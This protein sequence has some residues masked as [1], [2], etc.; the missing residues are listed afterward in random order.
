MSI[1]IESSVRTILVTG[2]CGF[3]GSNVVMLLMN[4]YSHIHVVNLDKMDYNSRTIDGLEAERYTFVHGN[5]C[6]ES[7]VLSLLRDHRVDVVMHFA[8]QSHVDRSFDTPRLFVEDNI[9]GTLSLMRA[10]HTYGLLRCLL[11]F[12]TDEIYGDDP[13]CQPFTEESALNPTNP[14][15]A[16]K[17]AAEMMVRSYI[18][19]FSIPVV[20]AR[21]NNIYGPRQYKDKVIP[22]FADRLKKGLVCPVH[23]NGS[24][25]RSFIHVRDVY[26]AIKCVLQKGAPGEVYNIGSD[27]ELSILELVQHIQDALGIAG[28]PR[29]EHIEDRPYNDQRYLIDDSKLRSLGWSPRCSLA[30]CLRDVLM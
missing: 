1:D 10:I 22:L 20:I 24:Q 3:V 14:Y 28:P 9:Q 25:K 6:D 18:Q 19:S 11:H 8:A 13:E 15:S 30:H 16:T 21:C 4:E 26:E 2:G 29:V 17:A 5:V 12:S 23:G 27:E 7:L